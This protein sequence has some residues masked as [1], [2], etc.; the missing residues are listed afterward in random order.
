MPAPQP[1]ATAGRREWIALA[2]L[3][4]PAVLV[5][6]NMSML[7]LAL[8]GLSADLD[9]TGPQLLWIIDVYGFMV[10]GFLVTLGTLGDRLGHRRVLVAGAVAFTI[11][12]VLAAFAPGAAWLVAAR[13]VQGI[14]AACL[15][16]SSLSLIRTMFRD[17]RQRTLAITIWM[18]SFM[19]GGALG[20]LIGGVL[21]EYFW[22]GSMFLTAVPTMVVLLVCAP[23]LLP[24]TPRS[25]AARPDAASVALSLVT[26]LVAVY[27]IK[28]LAVQGLSLPGLGTLAVGVLAGVFFARRQRQ[29]SVPFLDL[30]LFHVPAFAV[31][32][33]GMTL[34]GFLL[35]GTSLLTSQYLQLVL[36]FS[37]L[38][39]GLWQLP[40]A[41]F[42]TVTALVVS[43]LAVRFR[44]AVLMSAGA[45]L[46]ILGPVLLTQVNR[47]P[48][49]LVGG[50]VVL[51]AGLTPFMSLGSGLI[52]NSAPPERAGA[53]SAISETGAELGGALGIAVLGSVATAVYGRHLT[54]HLPADV[55]TDIVTTARETLPAALEVAS[56]LPHELGVTLT[57]A[58]RDAFAHSLHIH[59][60]ILIPLLAVLAIL[61]ITFCREPAQRD[62]TP[63]AHTE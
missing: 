62:G 37:P 52:L 21:L 35:F 40:S 6:M 54:E 45:A 19:G 47:G 12:S 51:F 48:L 11:A 24:E 44:P 42:S 15:A 33:G 18:L 2:V 27:A 36:G 26:P 32:A 30:G 57:E 43:G 56:R 1:T 55:P 23:F 60:I 50:S 31:A 4:V 59:A 14:A 39:A 28:E 34:V 20:P 49:V 25:G 7:Y 13:A 63:S 53:A 41:V 9:P 3:G 8:P 16:P 5:M 22:W 61:T 17:E 38:Q 46:A 29:L 10:A 58:A